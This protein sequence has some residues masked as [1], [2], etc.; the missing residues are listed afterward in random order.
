[1][2]FFVDSEVA[3]GTAYN[4]DGND[5][6]GSQGD[7]TDTSYNSLAEAQ[8][9]VPANSVINMRRGVVQVLTTGIA[10][11][12]NMTYSPWNDEVSTIVNN[13][14]S[15]DTI[16][17]LEKITIGTSSNRVRV[18]GAG[19]D[20]RTTRCIFVN[21]SNA[22]DSD[23]NFTVEDYLGIP[24]RTLGASAGGYKG[25]IELINCRTAAALQ[26][27][28]TTHTKSELE[29]T[30]RSSG[31]PFGTTNAGRCG[32]QVTSGDFDLTTNLI[33]AGTSL[34][35]SGIVTVA[36]G[37]VNIVGGKAVA[38]G[39]NNT[40]NVRPLFQRISGTF[41]VSGGDFNGHVIRPLT[42]I[43]E[44]TVTVT[45]GNFNT[46]FEID[47][48]PEFNRAAT[49]IAFDSNHSSEESGVVSLNLWSDDFSAIGRAFTWLPDDS[50][51]FTP[52]QVTNGEYFL[53][54]GG[55]L[56]A[57]GESSTSFDRATVE[58]NQP[59]K[60]YRSSGSGAITIEITSTQ[61]IVNVGGSPVE[62]WTFGTDVNLIGHENTLTSNY[63]FYRLNTTEFGSGNFLTCLP[64]VAYNDVAYPNQFDDLG[65]TTL[66]EGVY[67][68]PNS[69]GPAVSLWVNRAKW[70]NEDIVLN[71]I[72]LKD[73]FP[74][75]PRP[76][77]FLNYKLFTIPQD[78]TDAIKGDNFNINFAGVTNK[79]ASVSSN[80]TSI[81]DQE[82][83]YAVGAFRNMS[84]IRGDTAGDGGGVGLSNYTKG[85]DASNQVNLTQWANATCAAAAAVGG[86]PVVELSRKSATVSA[87]TPAQYHL[88]PQDLSTIVSVFESNGFQVVTARDAAK[89][90]R[91]ISQES[92]LGDTIYSTIRDS[93]MPS[94][95]STVSRSIS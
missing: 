41:E 16:I 67:V 38:C 89:T 93:L 54:N 81:I 58:D 48:P 23:M 84:D 13:V 40:D 28:T 85:S 6:D 70:F 12:K 11:N 86:Y 8:V 10:F 74:T 37:N 17:I 76:T 27:G 18:I 25:H 51:Q 19:T 90:I 42:T 87:G 5:G 79:A 59:F 22:S 57:E 75:T 66:E 56:G 71:R 80:L 68:V 95:N 36:G 43:F 62:T 52:Q 2:A 4:P 1:M 55:E 47:E 14:T 65:C 15:G 39:I 33:G 50:G 9:A 31:E 88:T 49:F 60:V 64:N 45:G 24:F 61:C 77:S 83:L 78:A 29:F 34:A 82:N 94:I 21:G 32:L 35:S 92:V 63:L 91:G 7:G 73:L 72:N 26:N 20:S 3:S 46:Y 53:A 30:L 44:G 69:A